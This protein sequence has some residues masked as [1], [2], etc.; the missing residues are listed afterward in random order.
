MAEPFHFRC[1]A[2]G[3]CCATAPSLALGEIAGQAHRFVLGFRLVPVPALDPLQHPREMATLHRAAFGG[4]DT[5]SAI[6]AGRWRLDEAR[7]QGTKMGAAYLV[8]D[9]ADIDKG[10]SCPHLAPDGACGVH[11]ERPGACRVV[12]FAFE[13]GPRANATWGGVRWRTAAEQAGWACSFADTEPVVADGHKVTDPVALDGWA[14]R[15]AP[16]PTMPGTTAELAKAVVARA[17]ALR[18][19]T[20]PQLADALVRAGALGHATWFPGALIGAAAADLGW[21]DWALQL[22]R[23]SLQ[24]LDARERAPRPTVFGGVETLRTVRA[25]WNALATLL[26]GRA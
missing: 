9:C 21:T 17:A 4:T 1:T 5:G 22:T 23:S 13:Q 7:A 14:R 20:P 8:V 12:P 16:D 10:G 19:D 11:P 18:G 3:R 24:A 15:Q 6:A 2:C 25:Q 26:A